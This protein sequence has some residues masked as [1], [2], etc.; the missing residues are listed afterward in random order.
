[1]DKLKYFYD[2]E[3]I[4][5]AGGIELVSIGMVCEDGRTFYAE[6]SAFDERHADQWVEDNVLSQLKFWGTKGS[7][8]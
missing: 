6:N 3:F 7:G 1:M 8:K 2:T 5:W 4:E